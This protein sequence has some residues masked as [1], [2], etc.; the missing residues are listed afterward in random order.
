[1]DGSGACLSPPFLPPSAAGA[2]DF[3]ESQ[4]PLVGGA[5]DIRL[6]FLFFLAD[7]AFFLWIGPVVAR[8]VPVPAYAGW[9]R[10]TRGRRRLRRR[11]AAASAL[12]PGLAPV[13]D[14]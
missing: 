9:E 1:M 3:T 2:T 4:Y 10:A 7:H 11:S 5:H 13:F 6:G 8:R 14:R 12:G